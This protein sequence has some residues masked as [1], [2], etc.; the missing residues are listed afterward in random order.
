MK[1]DIET[2]SDILDIAQSQMQAALPPGHTFNQLIAE[3]QI[4]ILN[5]TGRSEG[6]AAAQQ[7]LCATLANAVSVWHPRHL[8]CLDYLAIIEMDRGALTAA[9]EHLRLGIT[10]ATESAGATSARAEYDLAPGRCASKD[11]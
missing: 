5:Q 2:A 8:A 3:D 6:A 10:L 7:A 9:G 1:G 4:K 11:G